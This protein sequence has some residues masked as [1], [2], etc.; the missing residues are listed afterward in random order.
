MNTPPEAPVDCQIC[1]RL[2]EFRETNKQKFPDF[3]NGAVP[4]FGSDDAQLLIVGLAPGLKGA[5]WSGRPFTGDAAGDILYETLTEYGFASGTYK[6]RSDDGLRL[7]DTMI[8]NAVRCVPPQNKPLGGEITH[9]RPFLNARIKQLKGLKV[10]MALGRIAHE[11]TLRSQQKKL[12]D[13]PFKHCARHE[14]DDGLVLIDSY[15][16]SRYN[17]NTRRLT[18]PMFQDVFDAIDLE[19]DR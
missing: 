5:N 14:L 18:K 1:S 12:A 4:S 2:V 3:F 6:A 10:I 8:T 15:H 13:Y 7:V 17:L 11:S 16:C 9:C 19:L